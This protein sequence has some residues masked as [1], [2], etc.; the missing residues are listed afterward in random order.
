MLI[1]CSHCNREYE[2][3]DRHAK[4][5]PTGSRCLL[6][7]AER[8]KTRPEIHVGDDFG[9]YCVLRKLTADYWY[10]CC[11]I[12]GAQT[13]LK[14]A[15]LYQAQANLRDCSTCYRKNKTHIKF[16]WR[17]KHVENRNTGTAANVNNSHG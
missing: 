5:K 3:T 17:D 12:C 14:S 15:S 9:S 7:E 1:R 11:T 13:A 16:G 2:V 6:C 8:R 4:Q 10:V